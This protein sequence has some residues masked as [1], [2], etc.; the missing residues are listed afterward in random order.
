ML[1]LFFCELVSKILKEFNNVIVKRY[2]E[3]ENKSIFTIG[4]TIIYT[5]RIR[6]IIIK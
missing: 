3:I 5:K 2:G 6:T 1:I 4:I